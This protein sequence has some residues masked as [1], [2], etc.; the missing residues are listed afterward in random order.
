LRGQDL[1]G[2]NI[3]EAEPI[4]VNVECSPKKLLTFDFNEVLIHVHQ[5][6]LG[7]W[8]SDSRSRQITLQQIELPMKLNDRQLTEFDLSSVIQRSEVSACS[9]A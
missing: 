9:H 1:I 5:H 4:A 7:H 3:A 8:R 2:R 6:D